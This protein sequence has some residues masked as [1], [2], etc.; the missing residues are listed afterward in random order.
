MSFF[1]L[2][3]CKVLKD[4]ILLSTIGNYYTKGMNEI[5]YYN[6]FIAFLVKIV[7]KTYKSIVLNKTK[8]NIINIL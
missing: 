7:S 5:N 8:K 6:I 1:S 4:N 3:H 2:Y